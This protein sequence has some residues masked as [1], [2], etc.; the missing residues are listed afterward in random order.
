MG[1]SIGTSSA[2]ESRPVTHDPALFTSAL[3]EF[4][5]DEVELEDDPI[6]AD[7][8]LLLTGLVDSLGVVMIVEWIE[9]RLGIEI[10]PGDVVLEHFRTVAAMVG[11]V[12]DRE[13]AG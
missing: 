7:T 1:R 5:S 8:D 2:N 11:Y 13:A 6:E 9:D 10:D 12:S 3:L 4:I